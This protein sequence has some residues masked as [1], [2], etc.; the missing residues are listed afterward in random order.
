MKKQKSVFDGVDLSVLSILKTIVML[1]LGT[2]LFTI[3]PPSF[4]KVAVGA[5]QTEAEFQQQCVQDLENNDYP[6][7][8][9][10]DNVDKVVNKMKTLR[11]FLILILAIASA[12]ASVLS[13]RYGHRN[14][15][16]MSSV[17]TIAFF[18]LYFSDSITFTQ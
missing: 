18:M 8:I 13:M 5:P 14:E 7:V 16:F 17:L 3:L 10:E 2:V 9:I 1:S 12:Y 11:D 4:S 15:V 6:Y